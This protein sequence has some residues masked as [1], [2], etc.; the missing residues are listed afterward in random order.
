MSLRLSAGL[1]LL[2]EMELLE[3]LT[4]LF[5][6]DDLVP[7]PSGKVAD[8][9]DSVRSSPPDFLLFFFMSFFA[10]IFAP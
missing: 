2:E 1:R 3:E 4:E 9:L 5:R 8:F 10:G 7:M 6:G